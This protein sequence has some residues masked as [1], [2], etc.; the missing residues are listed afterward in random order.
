MSCKPADN[1][2]LYGAEPLQPTTQYVCFHHWRLLSLVQQSTEGQG[3]WNPT[4]PVQ[5]PAPPPTCCVTWDSLTLSLSFLIVM[6]GIVISLWCGLS[7]FIHGNPSELWLKQVLPM[8]YYKVCVVWR[9]PVM[10]IKITDW[11]L[12][13]AHYDSEIIKRKG[14]CSST[15]IQIQELKSEHP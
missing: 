1:L 3:L 11:I 2:G 13:S 7:E 6:A 15:R 9:F 10:F 5:I 8:S 14:F 12:L 4:V